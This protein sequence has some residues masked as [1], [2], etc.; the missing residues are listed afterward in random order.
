MDV[1][2]IAGLKIFRENFYMENFIGSCDILALVKSGSF[3]VEANGKRYEVK[4]NEATVF[5]KNVLYH[6]TVISPV[7]M[8]FFR[9]RSD[10][11][12]FTDGKIV[13]KDKSRITSTFALL[14]VLDK[15]VTKDEYEHR[16]ALFIDIVNQY[17]LENLTAPIGNSAKRSPIEL[18][19]RNING[20]I[21]KKIALPDIAMLTGLSYVQFIRR[22]KAETGMTPSDY[23]SALRI[24]KARAMLASS[25]FTVKEIAYA[26][27]FENEYYFSNFFK[28]HTGI[29]PTAF[30]QSGI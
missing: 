8:Y 6:R 25:T 10:E 24:Q 13:F 9:Y 28:K 11:T 20:S 3:S 21:H 16:S 7:T 1:Q 19:I 26:C 29:S 22:F 12:L 17:R 5:R 23:I 15:S 2:L 4:E 27:G 14:D 30:R 18:A